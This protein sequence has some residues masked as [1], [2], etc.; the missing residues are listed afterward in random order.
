MLNYLQT[1]AQRARNLEDRLARTSTPSRRGTSSDAGSRTEPDRSPRDEGERAAER[2]L[3]AGGAREVEVGPE[4]RRAAEFILSAEELDADTERAVDL[5][6]N[7]GREPEREDD[8]KKDS[9]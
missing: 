2:I 5:I 1:P 4:A 7:A 3:N 6:K 9:R 8:P